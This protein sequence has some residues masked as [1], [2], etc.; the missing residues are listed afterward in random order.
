M[1]SAQGRA[2]EVCPGYRYSSPTF[3]LPRLAVAKV[4]MSGLSVLSRFEQ[5]TETVK[6]TQA[7]DNKRYQEQKNLREIADGTICGHFL[8]SSKERA[9][10]IL[11]WQGLAG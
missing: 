11:R 5:L 9:V 4:S 10:H 7:T 1:K 3:R 8:G 6:F 2:G